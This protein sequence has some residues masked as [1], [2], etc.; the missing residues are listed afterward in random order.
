M[1][2]ESFTWVGGDT[3]IYSNQHDGFDK[4]FNRSPMEVDTAIIQINS[5]NNIFDLK[6]DDFEVVGYKSHPVIKFP[7]AAV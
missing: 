2:A 6:F 1:V 5:K 3:H 7:Q 4:Q